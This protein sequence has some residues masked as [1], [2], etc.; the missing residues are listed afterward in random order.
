MPVH[1]AAPVTKRL[2]QQIAALL[3]MPECTGGA[4]LAAALRR[5]QAACC[6]A[7]GQGDPQR[8]FE[9]EKQI[10][11][12]AHPVLL[13]RVLQSYE[14][15]GTARVACVSGCHCQKTILDGTWEQQATLMQIHGF[16]ASSCAAGLPPSVYAQ[17]MLH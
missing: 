16:K 11:G 2:W 1:L 3:L 13:S 4:S 14:G 12:G 5:C 10:S 7:A 8:R 9:K 15:M 6:G 17:R